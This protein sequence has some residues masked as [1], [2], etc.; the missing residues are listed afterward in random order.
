MGL[1][2][3]LVGSYNQFVGNPIPYSLVLK[4]FIG[5]TIQLV[6]AGSVAALFYKSKEQ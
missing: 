2:V 1:V 6:I 4:W 5:G 3:H